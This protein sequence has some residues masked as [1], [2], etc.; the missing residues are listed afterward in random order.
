M[1]VYI[2]IYLNVTMMPRGLRNDWDDSQNFHRGLPGTV[3]NF[4]FS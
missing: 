1:P 2:C 4:A 3:E